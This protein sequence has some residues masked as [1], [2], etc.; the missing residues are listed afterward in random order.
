MG[1][2]EESEVVDRFGLGQRVVALG[3]SG[4]REACGVVLDE[5][6][7]PMIG[8]SVNVVRRTVRDGAPGIH[9]TKG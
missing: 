1:V 5:T 6:G 9:A 7:A 3:C 8:V 4:H 2:V